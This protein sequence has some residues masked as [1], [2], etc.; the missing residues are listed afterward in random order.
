MSLSLAFAALLLVSEPQPVDSVAVRLQAIADSVLRARPRVPGI[1]LNVQ[2]TRLNKSWSIASGMSDTAL[3]VAI[4]PDQP[5][6]IASVT[7]TYTAATILRLVERGVIKLNDPISKHL[8][9]EFTSLLERDGYKTDSITI[10]HVLSHR[11]G[12]DEHTAVRSYIPMVRT[13]PAHQWTRLEQ[14]T[15]LVD[16]LQPIGKPDEKF[17]YSDTGY[18]LLGAIIERHTGK[19]Y[20]AAARELIGFDKLG[21]KSTW[22]ETMEPAPTGVAPRAHQ[23]MS[24]NDTY[25]LNPSFDL[26]GGGGVVTTTADMST[27]FSALI[28]GKVFDR[29]ATLDTMMAVRPAMLD[30]Y[31][32]GLFRINSN[33]TLGYG[34]SGFWGVL[35][36]NFP[37]EGLT[38]SVSVTEQ[39]QGNAVFA[40]L[41]EV[42]KSMK[43]MPR[44]N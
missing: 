19:N 29:K 26:Y 13:A 21:L 34:H 9:R 38:I 5:I 41:N 27:F 22:F 32:F 8:P 4:R 18:I 1:L 33:G 15:W 23:Y 10:E 6:R 31:G 2:S 37:T 25:N 24:G 40:V 39:S 42:L 16:S 14:V 17:K 7:K 28:G 43:A 36:A 11:S 30:G 35:S 44:T 20:G 3:K 12:L